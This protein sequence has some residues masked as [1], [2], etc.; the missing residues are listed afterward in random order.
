MSVNNYCTWSTAD[1]VKMPDFGAYT[2][3]PADLNDYSTEIEPFTELVEWNYEDAKKLAEKLL[4]VDGMG[5]KISNATYDLDMMSSFNGNIEPINPRFKTEFCRNF[6][7]KGSCQYGDH[8]QFAHGK[9]ELRPDVVRHSKYK[10]KLCQKY[11]IAGYCAYGARCNFIHQQEDTFDTKP[12]P[13]GLRPFNPNFRRS[14]ESSVD[15]GVESVFSQPSVFSQS[16]YKDQFRMTSNDFSMREP[17][18]TTSPPRRHADLNLNTFTDCNF[19]GDYI[20][21]S[22]SVPHPEHNP[23]QPTSRRQK[24]LDYYR[25]CEAGIWNTLL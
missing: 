7:E 16:K 14:S 19:N 2:S 25:S 6:R 9:N 18:L 23:I 5:D 12:A 13:T 20:K 8:C 10:T 17:K 22:C 24:D 4:I 21:G 15:S 11:W 3:D 1:E